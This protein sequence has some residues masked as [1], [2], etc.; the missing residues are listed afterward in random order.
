MK[1][2]K[3]VRKPWV[4]KTIYSTIVL[5]V[6]GAVFAWFTWGALVDAVR[7]D[8][9][10]VPDV[11]GMP[12][13]EARATLNAAGLKSSVGSERSVYSDFVPRGAVAVQ[14]PA[15]ESHV[16][17]ARQ[18]EIILSRGSRKESIPDLTGLNVE[19]AAEVARSYQMR[20][21]GIA[22]M[23]DRR[24]AGTVVAQTPAPGGSGIV[25]NRI[26]LLIS[27]GERPVRYVMPDLRLR[28]L[29]EVEALLQRN[30]TQYV[31]KT[32]ANQIED[33]NILFIKQQ[34]PLP[35]HMMSA[36]DVVTLKVVEREAL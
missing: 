10:V 11:I 3:W 18:V 8:I 32:F 1:K 28:P 9:V 29:T 22:R 20:L 36:D 12:L 7:G 17:F 25:D 35:G 16:K 15:P 30:R 4:R 34:Y 24:P 2:P 31:V 21:T 27:E 5:A 13:P 14:D 6:C 26:K 33:R 19:E 23:H